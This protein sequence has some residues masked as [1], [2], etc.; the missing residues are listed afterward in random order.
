MKARLIR[1]T[2]LWESFKDGSHYPFALRAVKSEVLHRIGRWKELTFILQQDMNMAGRYELNKEE[3]R[4]MLKL[5]VVEAQRGSFAGARD[6]AVR[7][8]EKYRMAGDDWGVFESR[9]AL[10]KIAIN[11]EE[12]QKAEGMA[13]ELLAEARQEGSLQKESEMLNNLGL[14][15]LKTGRG[16]EAL[17]YFNKKLALV[18]TLG[19][20][21]GRAQALGNI[22][23][24]HYSNDR[25]AEAAACDR[26]SIEVSRRI[27][28]IYSEYFAVYNLAKACEGMGRQGEALEH[29]QRD[30]E[31]ARQLGDEPGEQ[32]ILEDL[33]RLNGWRKMDRV[34]GKDQDP[35]A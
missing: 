14:V 10:V 35:D 32:V 33:S 15:C 8:M 3:G 24:V 2:A 34:S 27:G 31:M 30:L 5:A 26:E 17:D 4:C 18:Q 22:G 12:Y 23:C 29:Y 13:L 9:S 1:K 6:R 11:L 28:D 7:A 16:E 20:N 19:E 21:A 25:F